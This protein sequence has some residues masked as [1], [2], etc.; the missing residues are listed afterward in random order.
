MGYVN[1]YV[2]V[3]TTGLTV[4]DPGWE[5]PA[6]REALQ[7]GLA[8]LGAGLGDVSHILV[9]HF[10]ADHYGAAPWLSRVSGARIAMHASDAGVFDAVAQ[11]T[12]ERI[13]SIAQFLIA[14]G[15]PR[16]EIDA[17]GLERGIIDGLRG[18]PGPD[19]SLAADAVVDADGVRIEVLHTPGHTKGHA[20]FYV[21]H[22]E[23]LLS[24]DHILP[25][26]SPNVSSYDLGDNDPLGDYLGSLALL[27][28]RRVSQVLPGHEYRFDDLDARL[29][30]L[31]SHHEARL[32]EA[33]ELLD[34]SGAATSWQVA[35]GLRWSRPWEHMEPYARR[36]ANGEA[37]AHLV[38]MERMG[39]VERS[40]GPV[41][42]WSVVA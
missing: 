34:V 32:D 2:F 4:V 21:P 11:S 10:H 1:C 27:R 40:S 14:T 5:F 31:Q 22:E 13:R 42:T 15:A 3:G 9:T 7:R 23:L 29:D 20:C 38:L 6:G 12:D 28:Q 17:L 37:L 30:E 25:R 8:R 19:E 39:R 41:I 33:S 24:G 26:I 16:D 35:E 36:S 18:T